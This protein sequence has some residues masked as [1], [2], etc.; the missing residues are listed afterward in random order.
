MTESAC[1][2][3]ISLMFGRRSRLIAAFALALALGAC[4]TRLGDITGSIGRQTTQPTTEAGW[5]T[6]LDQWAKRYSATPNDRNTA[7]FYARALRAT[8]Q[9]AQTMAVLQTAVLKHGEDLELLGAYGRSLADNGRLK[10]ADEVLGRAHRPEQPNWRILSVQGTVADQLGEHLRAQ[11][12]YL[13]ALKI[14]PDEPTIMS[15]LGLSYALTKRLPE[16]EQVLKRAAANPQA[17]MR[18]RQNLVMVLGLQGKFAEAEAIARQDQSPQE[19][20]ATVA[21]LKN[22]V[23]QPNNWDLLKKSGQAPARQAGATRPSTAPRS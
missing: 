2:S 1:P 15:N 18:V 10:E 19:A 13:T 4:Q 3:S 11:E 22:V 14:V 17:D 5:R 7:F 9:H 12:I 6:E 8:G 21:S 16:A 23:S 20:A